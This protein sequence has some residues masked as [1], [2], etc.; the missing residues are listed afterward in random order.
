MRCAC[1]GNRSGASDLGTM[2]RPYRFATLLESDLIK[3]VGLT[4]VTITQRDR[5]NSLGDDA[6]SQNLYHASDG[7]NALPADFNES[8]DEEAGR[9]TFPQMTP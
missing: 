9:G 2:S 4:P 5:A 1:F 8:I 7:R 6:T 3:S